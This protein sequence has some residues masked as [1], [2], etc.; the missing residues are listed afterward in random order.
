MFATIE[1]L[2]DLRA[3]GVLSEDEFASKKTELF[4]P[5]LKPLSSAPS[6]RSRARCGRGCP[7]T[8]VNSPPIRM[9]SSA[10][11]KSTETFPSASGSKFRSTAPSVSSRARK[12]RVSKPIVVKAPPARIRPSAYKMADTEGNRRLQVSRP[13]TGLR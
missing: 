7:P 8:A 4:A 10:C 11:S 5:G 1:K 13:S 2:A 12:L 9:L 3:K 6:A